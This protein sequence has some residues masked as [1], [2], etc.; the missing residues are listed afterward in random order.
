MSTSFIS[1]TLTTGRTLLALAVALLLALTLTLA[2]SAASSGS[3]DGA[4]KLRK[5]SVVA[6][7]LRYG[8]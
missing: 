8:R 4:E 3:E 2:A 1:T 7:K 5:Y 6:E